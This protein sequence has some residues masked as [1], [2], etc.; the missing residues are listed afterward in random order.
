MVELEVKIQP[1]QLQRVREEELGVEAGR[2]GSVLLEIVGGEL[3]DLNDRQLAAAWLSP[4]SCDA[5]SA[6]INADTR[7]SRSPAMT[8][9]SL[10]RVRLI[11]WSVK[12]FSLKLYVRSF[13]D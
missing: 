12:R 13:S 6:A 1:P 5:R 8:R 9:S 3:Q 7:S 2:I 11:R 4:F 10:C